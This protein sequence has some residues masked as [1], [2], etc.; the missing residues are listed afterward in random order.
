MS[1]EETE[2]EFRL[3][4]RLQKTLTLIQGLFLAGAFGIAFVVPLVFAKPLWM[5]YNKSIEGPIEF[6]TQRV[7]TEA[8]F[9]IRISGCLSLLLLHA[10]QVTQTL[11][12]VAVAWNLVIC[13]GF[14]VCRNLAKLLK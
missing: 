9:W 1:K 11:C 8:Q 5:I 10:F 13:L 2:A 14:F 7:S 6:W 4:Q 12:R 3:E